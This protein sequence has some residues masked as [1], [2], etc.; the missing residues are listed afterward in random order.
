MVGGDIF[1]GLFGVAIFLAII[2][3][4]RAV[5]TWYLKTTDILEELKKAN[6]YLK[7]TRRRGE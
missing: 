1:V 5:T 4:L 7:K 6:G 2:L 3:V